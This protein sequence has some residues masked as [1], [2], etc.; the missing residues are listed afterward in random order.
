MY[1]DI[2]VVE[3]TNGHTIDCFWTATE[4]YEALSYI[5]LMTYCCTKDE[6]MYSIYEL[7]TG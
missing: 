3:V 4:T 1:D 2:Y 5:V 6:H 7:S